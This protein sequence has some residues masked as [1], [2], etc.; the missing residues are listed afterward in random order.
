MWEIL[1]KQGSR[2][3]ASCIYS[4]LLAGKS[5]SLVHFTLGRHPLYLCL[6]L[7]LPSCSGHCTNKPRYTA[8]YGGNL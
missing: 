3:I 7:Q 5:D 4:L 1:V 8:L 2:E 6:P